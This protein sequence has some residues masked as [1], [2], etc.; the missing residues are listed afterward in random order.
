MKYFYLL[1]L[2]PL[3]AKAQIIFTE[4]LATPIDTTKQIQGTIAPEFNFKTERENFFQLKNNAN[5]TFLVKNRHALTFLNQVEMIRSGENISVNNG[6]L[7]GEYR[8]I[9]RKAIEI[10]PF[11][12]SGWTP[13]RGL[14]LKLA[15]GL[16]SRFHLI[17]TNHFIWLMGLGF[18]GEYEQWNFDGVPLPHNYVGHKYQRSI[19]SQIHTGLKFQLTEKW[20]LIASAYMHNRLDSNIVNPRWALALDLRHKITEHFGVWFSYQ[21]LYH[22]RPIVPIRKGYTVT[23]GGV[24]IS[25]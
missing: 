15:A 21:Y 7:H 9:V 14:E 3:L 23:T 17:H 10:Y 24:F 18:F 6:F 20:L 4:S 1:F 13:S 5:I 12:E 16:Q 11:M 25:F 2:M 22:T 8:Y 19:K